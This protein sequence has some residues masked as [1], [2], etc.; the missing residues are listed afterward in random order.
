[1]ADHYDVMRASG[2]VRLNGGVIGHIT[3]GS[4]S[5]LTTEGVRRAPGAWAEALMDAR[6]DWL[7]GRVWVDP[8]K[9]DPLSLTVSAALRPDLIWPRCPRGSLRNQ[10]LRQIRSHRS[11][12]ERGTPR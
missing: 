7:T 5:L 4:F 11:P 1:M 8:V 9:D 2:E 10:V 6:P 12:A 3:D